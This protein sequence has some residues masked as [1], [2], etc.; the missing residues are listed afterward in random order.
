MSL[1]D[2]HDPVGW[3]FYVY[4]E[5]DNGEPLFSFWMDVDDDTGVCIFER[6]QGAGKWLGTHHDDEDYSGLDP[7]DELEGVLRDICGSGGSVDGA[8]VEALPD[9]ES[10]FFRIVH[11]T[12]EQ[13]GR[14]PEELMAYLMD[15]TGTELTIQ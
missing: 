12:I 13:K 9:H 14:A 3:R 8:R 11:G 4:G 5:D 7:S 10:Y 1:L 15:L 6:N 2:H